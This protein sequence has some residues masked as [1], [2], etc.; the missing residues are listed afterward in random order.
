[1]TGLVDTAFVS[2]VRGRV[3]DRFAQHITRVTAA[4]AMFA[5]L[6]AVPA[7]NAL[8]VELNDVA[9]D[10]IERQR[11]A[12]Q[13]QIP[14]P[15]TPNLAQLSE[16]L[17]AKG[18]H[19]GAPMFIR[20]FKAES[21]LEVWMEKDGRYVLFATYP[22]CHWSGTLG[23]KQ[24]EGDKQSPEGVY[25]LTSQQLHWIGRWP[26]SLNL[27]FPN[28]LD[29]AF[30]RTGSYIL[31]HGGCSSVGC[32][33]MTNPVIEEIFGLAHQA[34]KDGQ[35]HIQV[36]ALPFRMT[37]E[38][39]RAHALSEWYD[40]WRNLKDAY[41]SFERTRIPPNVSVCEGRY[42][43]RDTTTAEEVASHD[44]LALCGVT[45]AAQPELLTPALPSSP[46]INPA[47][48]NSR[49][50][51]LSSRRPVST[52]SRLAI[53]P[54]QNQNLLPQSRA[55]NQPLATQATTSVR[56]VNR[57]NLP[58][59]LRAAAAMT[60]AVPPTV[61]EPART[62]APRP[63]PSATVSVPISCE[64]SRPSCRKWVTLQRRIV[65]ERQ[66]SRP[67]ARFAERR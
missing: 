48:S 66:R 6:L 38:R 63:S 65:A 53:A 45:A 55:P 47:L 46:A 17:A 42:H 29:R 49:A 11:A 2:Q 12:S 60:T 28:V 18:L 57:P 58:S 3:A 62:S 44:P 61:A 41:D 10:R 16:R 35:D 32:F 9:S 7:A 56:L 14:L 4:G 54:R 26:R 15:N 5:A 36:Q 39:M 34:L 24:N 22:I 19:S 59:D 64:I 37:D 52:T 13:G 1:M 67:L 20:I 31:I 8:V 51:T 43:V 21:E 27:G 33:A 40:F 50:L 23:P 25:T 30:S